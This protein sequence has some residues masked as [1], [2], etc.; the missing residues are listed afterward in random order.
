MLHFARKAHWMS[1]VRIAYHE[2]GWDPEPYDAFCLS[3]HVEY[4]NMAVI[5]V[6]NRPAASIF[7]AVLRVQAR[8]SMMSLLF[9]STTSSAR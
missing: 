3:R 1:F 8:S 7:I 6:R 4:T 2:L 5:N 9:M